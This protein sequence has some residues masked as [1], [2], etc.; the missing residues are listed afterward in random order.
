MPRRA[1]RRLKSEEISPTNVAEANKRAAFD[2]EMLRR[3]DNSMVKPP[4]LRATCMDP[5]NNFDY[6][7]DDDLATINVIPTADAIDVTGRPI[8]QQS[9][10]DL[11]INADV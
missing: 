10:T 6:K 7:S 11:L 8:Y 9:V 3:L 1:L 4:P 5:T 2:A